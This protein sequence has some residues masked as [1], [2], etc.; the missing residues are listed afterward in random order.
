MKTKTKPCA[1]WAGLALSAISLGHANSLVTFQVDMTD[2]I[3]TAAFD[4]ATQTVA[5]RGTF[6]AWSPFALTNNPTGPNSNLWTGTYNVTSNVYSGTTVSAN[7][8]VMSYKYTVEPGATYESV[9]LGGSHNR[10]ITLPS[11]SGASIT[12]PN[13]HFS[14]IAL[15]PITNLVTF[16]VDLAQQINVGAFDPLSST[17]QARGLFNGWGGTAIAQTNDP[18]I[19]RTNQNGLVTSNVYVGTYEIVGSP[20]QTM[21]YKYYIDLNSNWESPAPSSGDP[22]DNNNRFFNLGAGP[23]QAVPIVFFNDSPYA[24]LATNDITFQVDMTAQIL[25]GSFDPSSSYVELRG[26]FNG[27]GTPQILC[28]NDPAGPNTNLYKTVVEIKDGVGA[29]HSYKFW[30]SG[31][32]RR[33]PQ[34]NS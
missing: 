25:L 30:A 27:W 13:V 12:T 19:L 8:T 15:T 21:D 11:T 29:L 26:D 5:A 17:V 16:Q 18:S 9:Y 31:Y 23:T 22:V 7:G 20:G 28:T 24:P 10:L 2:A 34:S 4:P 32:H 6:N 33:P 1:V 3:A 14:D